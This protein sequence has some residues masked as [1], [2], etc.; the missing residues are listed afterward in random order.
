MRSGPKPI[1]YRTL[2]AFAAIL[3]VALIGTAVWTYEAN[4]RAP[5]PSASSGSDTIR[6]NMTFNATPRDNGSSC[7]RTTLLQSQTESATATSSGKA[8]RNFWQNGSAMYQ[9]GSSLLSIPANLGGYSPTL[10]ASDTLTI[11][12]LMPNGITPMLNVTQ[13]TSYLA[14]ATVPYSFSVSPT[15]PSTTPV[16]VSAV[17]AFTAAG[18][19]PSAAKY[20]LWYNWSWQVT[21]E[22]SSLP[23]WIL[24][25]GSVENLSVPV[26]VP[27][28]YALT[29]ATF[30][31]PFPGLALPNVST[32]NLTTNP[33]YRWHGPFVNLTTFTS[34]PGQGFLT[35]YVPSEAA[36]ATLRVHYVVLGLQTGKI[37]LLLMGPVSR[38]VSGYYSATAT[39]INTQPL[40]YAGYFYVQTNRSLSYAIVP[41]SLNVTYDY[42][43][44]YL[45]NST[46]TLSGNQIVVLPGSVT[47]YGGRV[48]VLTIKFLLAN[49]PLSVGLCL[50]CPVGSTSVPWWALAA[51]W[52]VAWAVVAGAVFGQNRDVLIGR[53]RYARAGQ[54]AT[55][56]F[57]LA[58]TLAVIGALVVLLAL[59]TGG[60]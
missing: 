38:L 11:T 30:T 44:H 5:A 26:A 8:N 50:T 24:Q 22:N 16:H 29:A 23:D 15:V 37:P 13:G 46:F 25:N 2:A 53:G 9:T 45:R 27:T 47:V 52:E 33:T 40:P 34:S 28:G 54:A 51:A 55:R 17:A 48:L 20:G 18:A 58:V 19:T 60:A 1:T 7:V 36:N 49:V 39:W 12:A 41:N 21:F 56:T 32:L 14:N 59:F 43:G 6:C 57:W 42:P 31:V 10:I 4:V 3:A 35:A